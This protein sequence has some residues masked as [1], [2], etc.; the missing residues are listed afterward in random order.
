MT[1]EEAADLAERL[2]DAEE[3]IELL[4]E[5]VLKTA[6]VVNDLLRIEIERRGGRTEPRPDLRLVDETLARELIL[7]EQIARLERGDPDGCAAETSP[8][9]HLRV[10]E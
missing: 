10:V 6:Q 4:N 3:T 8:V 9:R 1:A 7:R 5:R 2:A